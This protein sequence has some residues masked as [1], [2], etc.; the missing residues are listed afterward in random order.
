MPPFDPRDPFP[1]LQ[2]SYPEE[3]AHA[4]A[5]DAWLGLDVAGVEREL[6]ARGCRRRAPGR[7]GDLQ[8]LWLGLAPSSLLT[9]YCEIRRLLEAAGLR[10][11]MTVVDLGAAYGRMGFVVARCYPQSR[12]VGYEYAG[13]RVEE[14]ARALARFCRDDRA[15]LQHADLAS[16][17]FAP[18]PA[19]IYFIYDFGTLKA[20]EKA[21]HDLRRAAEERA[22]SVVARGTRCR[23]AIA[24][25]HGWLE[26]DS[27]APP[28]DRASVYRSADVNP[29]ASMEAEAEKTDAREA[30]A[31]A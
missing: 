20:I 15:V 12:F 7:S 30:D 8:E 14:G 4:F 24:R 10:D 27:R 3:Q 31:R 22:I 13:E 1:L 25:R 18:R 2:A 6:L 26:L 23:D 28:S 11:D 21:L 16:P 29:G 19:Q 5:A 9:P 17:L